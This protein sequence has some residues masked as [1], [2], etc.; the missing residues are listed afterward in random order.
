MLEPLRS[1][2]LVEED[3]SPTVSIA[4]RRTP[5][6]VFAFVGAV[7]SGTTT[8]AKLLG[9]ILHDEYGYTVQH[10]KVSDR[11][12]ECAKNVGEAFDDSL[13]GF[14]RTNRLQ[15]IGNRLR[16]EF[17]G[18]YIVEKC[19]EQIAFK[20][21]EEGYSEADAESG[22][23]AAPLPL[24]RAHLIDSLKHPEEVTI[25]REVYGEIFWLIAVFAP[26]DVREKRLVR[27]GF[28]KADIGPLMSRDEHEEIEYGQKVRQTIHLAD[29]F[30]RND[31]D[32]M[33]SL[34]ETA[35]RYC[36]ILF[37]TLI[38]TPTRDETAMFNAMAAAS[39]SACMS[40]Q[41]GASIYSE[42]GELIGIGWND[43]PKCD[44]GL[45]S[46]ED[47]DNDHRCYLWGDRVCHNDH[48]KDKLY[49]AITSALM[50]ERLISDA[51]SEADIR[52]VLKKTDIRSLIE[53][54][55]AVH[56]EME[57]II[58][59]ARGGKKGLRR[60]TLYSTTFPCHSCA[61]HIVASGIKRV[62]YVEPY[63]KSLALH[64]HDDAVSLDEKDVNKVVFLQY[65]G[66]APRNMLRLFNHG[67]DRKSEGAI[68]ER[69]KKSAFPVFPLP[70]D[71]YA[72]REQMVVVSLSEREKKRSKG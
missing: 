49:S 22:Q 69:D 58:S 42:K 68:I 1:R 3:D 15:D 61:R 52:R 23:A 57:A 46:V 44:G 36:S 28:S 37:N 67:V 45:Y 6:L 4:D 62:V 65:E 50:T 12:I 39:R 14:A 70:L 63:P 25:L 13:A 34:S 8:T 17:S 10:Y 35:S 47:K 72:T 43:V 41:V 19:I 24:R 33:S 40:R 71:S 56:A 16:E 51:A 48:E 20:R 64:L 7:A 29:F 59:V 21:A 2:A 32:N 11:I 30:V 5:E 55:R 60:A 54:S 53:F 18:E 66:V 31:K 38:Q 9:R 27:G 26:E